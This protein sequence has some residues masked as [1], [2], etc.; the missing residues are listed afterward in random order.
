MCGGRIR[1]LLLL[2]AIAGVVAAIVR[3]LRGEPAPQFSTHPSV[4]G[5]PSPEPS[6][7]AAPPGDPAP[8]REA[9][10]AGDADAPPAELEAGDAP[11]A[12]L[13][14]G[15]QPAAELA[16]PAAPSGAL[17]SGE[18]GGALEQVDGGETAWVDPVDG[19][20]PD[21]Y[22]IKAKLK[23]GIFHQ[24]GGLAYDRTKPDRCY[25]T[26]EAAEADGLRA[27]KR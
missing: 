20:C 11:V 16:A 27:A 8:E 17:E 4:L 1:K 9:T 13:P 21:G 19:A 25:A 26:A 14:T 24:P 15:D 5:G 7:P 22:P 6:T 10:A 2:A 12:E 3:A 18:E 23:S